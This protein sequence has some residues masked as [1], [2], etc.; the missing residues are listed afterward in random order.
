MGWKTYAGTLILIA[1]SFNII[2]GLVAI[3]RPTYYS[4]V[5]GATIELP[6]TNTI[7]T[8]GWVALI[9]GIVMV[10]A[11]LAIF[12]G[13]MWARIVGV[14]VVAANMLF[15]FA[16]LAHFP[17]WSFTMIVVGALAIY[18]LM[19]HGGAEA[20]DADSYASRARQEPLDL[21]ES[22]PATSSSEMAG[23]TS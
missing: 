1:G 16:Y 7:K 4:T 12:T 10:A 8:W 14:V 15:Q 22:A 19:A 20:Y 5:T 6:I 21:R 23:R 17:F 11:G 9:A 13:A 18:G 3:I 2:D